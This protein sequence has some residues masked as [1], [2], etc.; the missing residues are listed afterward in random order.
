MI[1][2]IAVKVQAGARRERVEHVS[3]TTFEI[4]VRE[5]A[6]HNAANERVIAILAR[7]F[8]VRTKDVALVKGHKSPS[9][10]FVI[11]GAID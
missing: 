7:H 3:A 11:R 10:S 2:P 1:L 9:K 8:H 4:A 6:E 5:A